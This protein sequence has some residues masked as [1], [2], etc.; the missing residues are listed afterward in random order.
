MVS[1]GLEMS[2]RTDE[3]SETRYCFIPRSCVVKKTTLLHVEHK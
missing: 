2:T 1:E 3:I